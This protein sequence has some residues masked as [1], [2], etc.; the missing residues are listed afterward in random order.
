MTDLTPSKVWF[1]D[2]RTTFGDG[3]QK[4]LSRL[5][6]AAG[7]ADIDFDHKFTAIKIHFGERGN[8]AFLRPNFA[9][10]VAD[11]IKALGGLPFLT[12]CNTLYPGSRKHALEHLETAAENGFSLLTCGCS[13]IIGDGIKGL[14]E[15]LVPIDGEYVSQAKIG[16]A[17]MDADIVVS[18][19]HFKGHEATGFGGAMKNIGMGCGSRAGK[20]EQHAAGKPQAN[21]AA[22]IG[23]G[24]CLASCAHGAITITNRKATVDHDRCVGCGRC[25]GACPTDAMQPGSSSTNRELCCKMAEY[26]YAVL[27][28]RPHFHISIV[29][30]VSPNCDCHDENDTPI[31]PDVGMFASFDPVALDQACADAVNSQPVISKSALG[32]SRHS[33]DG[34]HFAMVHP[35]TNWKDCLEHAEKMG[36]GQQSYELIRLS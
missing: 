14:D 19:N 22:C 21:Q 36:I 29:M 11:E 34:D 32:D 13:V 5:I 35:D 18:L 20:M 8:L 24:K 17:I 28:D 10:T 23:C 4:K 26:A 25:I 30:D 2:M 7:M 27:R 15:T 31:V 33:A 3:L 16:T 1:I 9:R 12:D 6:K